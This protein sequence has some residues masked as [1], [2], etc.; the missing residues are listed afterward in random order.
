MSPDPVDALVARLESRGYSPRPTG[1]D[2]WESRCPGHDGSRQNLSIKRSDDGRA[3]IHCHHADSCSHEAIVS[4]LDLTVADLFPPDPA[5]ARPS[6]NGKPKPRP[7]AERPAHPSPEAA[8]GSM[9]LG[10]PST[11]WSYQGPDGIE[12]LRV[13]RFDRPEGKTYRPVHRDPSGGWRPGDPPGP[14]PLYN[15]P[16]LTGAGRVYVT[17]GEKVCDRARETFGVIATTSA[18]GAQSPHKSDWTPLAGKEVVILPD[19]DEPGESYAVAVAGLLANLRPRPTVKIVRL[20]DLWRTDEPIPKGGDLAEWLRDGVPDASWT[21]LECRAELERLA[22]AAM[23]VDLDARPEPDPP[24]AVPKGDDEPP[25]PVPSWPDP[26]EAP[27]FSGLAGEIVRAIEPHTE[28]DPVAILAQLLIGFGSLI[29]RTAHFE[30][31]ADRHYSNEFA[32]LVG[33]TSKGRKGTSWGHVRR[34]LELIDPNWAAGRILGGLSTGEGLIHAVRDPVMKREPVRDNKRITG[35]QEI[36]ADAGESDKRLLAI[37]PELGGTL[38]IATRDGNTL[39]A[40]VRQ[41]WDSGDL[42]TLTRNC[43]LKATGAHISIIGHI[44]RDELARLLTQTEA[45]NGFANRFLWLAVRRSKLLPFGGCPDPAT[46]AD[47]TRRLGDAAEFARLTGRMARDADADALWADAYERLSEGRPGLL[48]AVTSRAEPHS[49]RLAM[50]YALLDRSPVIRADHLRA[51]LALWG[52]AERSARFIFG[53]AL[54]DPD[55]DALLDALRAAGPKGLTRTEIREEVF[56]KHKSAERIAGMLRTLAA[57]G[58]AHSRT[59]ATGGRPS[60]RWFAG[61]QA[62]PKAPYARYLAA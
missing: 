31:E 56:Q 35:Y 12:L 43:P 51:G 49:M 23:P 24:P 40:L 62:A 10:R 53:D 19:H 21:D 17:E 32:A 37:E 7:K 15:L 16:V 58:L 27:A 29:G 50:L 34:R 44:T 22:D 18:H 1:P 11:T 6:G 3:L 33:D 28:S 39:S 36:E 13:A 42:G 41:A 26:P 54:G 59:E 57:A 60:E 20:A 25:I 30:V 5:R 47:L 4:A 9:G 14:L 45:A 38:R 52:Y 61:R 8:I 55:A 48:G 2:S 46:I